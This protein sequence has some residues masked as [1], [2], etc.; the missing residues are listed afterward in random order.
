MRLAGRFDALDGVG[1][2]VDPVLPFVQLGK[3]EE[4][5]DVC[6]I[7]PQRVFERLKRLLRPPEQVL[8]PRGRDPD[9]GIGGTRAR[10]AERDLQALFARPGGD[11]RLG[12]FLMEAR[13]VGPQRDR[14]RQ[15]ST[16]PCASP[17]P[18]RLMPRLP[19]LSKS[20]GSAATISLEK[21]CRGAVLRPAQMDQGREAL[22]L[23]SLERGRAQQL[24]GLVEPVESDQQTRELQARN[25]IR[26]R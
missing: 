20:R 13:L 23:Q 12:P 2:F 4:R 21:L 14:P 3:G 16:A 6:G 5:R 9:Q 8:Q 1:E 25:R 17:I 19:Q 26:R 18:K 24:L 11:Q 22:G 10:L 15:S 7:D